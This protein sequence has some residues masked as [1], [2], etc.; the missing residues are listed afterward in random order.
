MGANMAEEQGTVETML[1]VI[2]AGVLGTTVGWYGFFL[3]GF[4][5]ATVFPVVFFPNLSPLDGVIA[6][7]II[8][9]VGFAA[10]PVGG[11]LFGWFG[12]RIGRRSTLAATMLLMS[13]ATTM[14]G[15]LPGYATLGVFA[16][17]LLII[18]RFLQGVGMGG[19][20]GGAVLLAMEYGDDRRRG[21]WTS[22]SQVSVPIA[23]AL[24]ALAVLFFE[25]LYPGMAFESI[26]W[27]MPFFLGAMLALVGFYIRLRIP[28]TPVF[29]AIKAEKKV[30][31]APL[32]EA[33]RYN[34]REILCATLARAGEQA[35]FYLFT[36]FLFSYGV[37]TLGLGV[38]LLNEGI[39]LGALAS[40]VLMP[41]FAAISD[42]VGRKLWFVMGMAVTG[43]YA[44]PYFW[45]LATKDP[46]CV[47]LAI[48]L[49]LSICHAW[50]YGV[51]AALIAEQF[52][53]PVRYTG[54]SLGF[55]LASLVFGG[56]AP[57]IATYLLANQARLMPE[58]PGYVLI[59]AYI[60]AMV[61]I[62]LIAVLF[63]NEYAGRAPAGNNGRC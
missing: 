52:A 4:F 5:A 32:V 18:L 33:F 11:A 14:I 2:S 21:F 59:A 49:S 61:V 43:V 39:V 63:L 3:C 9:F 42:R 29:S 60:V 10:R 23:L 26:G 25:Y 6:A 13:I 35:P 16:W 55:Q 48:L 37:G 58:Y 24:S 15:V 36:T 28:E 40:C 19:E 51:Q 12:D 27:R 45:L 44:V 57:L 54:A 1:P 8:S 56:P 22:W 62:S 46:W 20:W 34:W 7:F 47:T 30:V 38:S 53:T 41:T 17:F 50:T 31:K